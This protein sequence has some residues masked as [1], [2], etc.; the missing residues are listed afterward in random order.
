MADQDERDIA[1]LLKGKPVIQARAGLL[2][3]RPMIQ[4][5]GDSKSVGGPAP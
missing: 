1:V 3:E 4:S 5:R 2:Q